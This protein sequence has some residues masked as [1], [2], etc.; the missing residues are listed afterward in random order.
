MRR[1]SLALLV[2][3]AAAVVI[4]MPAAGV[5]PGALASP[6]SAGAAARFVGG[7]FPPE[8]APAYLMRV[9]GLMAQTIAIS[10]AGTAI[11]IGVAIPLA[12]AALR[13]RGEERGRESLGATRWS[14][15]WAAR[16]G[17]RLALNLA[18]AVPELVWALLFVVMVGL[19]PFAGVLALAA[20]SAGVLGK[21]YSELLESV[22]QGAVD[23]VRGTGA[24]E[25]QVTLLARVPLALP[26]LLSYTLFRWECNLR[27]ATVLGL[28]GAGGLGTELVLAFRLF[29][30][31][32]LLTLIF[33]IL[34]LVAL[35]DFT[36]QLVRARVLDAPTG[37]ACLPE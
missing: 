20:H 37:Q 11:A 18:R 30:Y 22:D 36:G 7:L 19:G 24:N 15:A 14:L 35:I 32:E 4:A 5:D 12:L 21:L 9:V 17:V 13:L 34:L 8:L 6:D 26:V 23:A 10:V 1:G 27:A 29:R 2:T 25:L 16:L 28:V 31:H 33:A 3:V